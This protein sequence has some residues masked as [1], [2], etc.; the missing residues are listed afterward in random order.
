MYHRHRPRA[1]FPLLVCPP[2][3][4]AHQPLPRT[5]QYRARAR[6]RR[7][8]GPSRRPFRQNTAASRRASAR[9]P[10][11]P[12][13]PQTRHRKNPAQ[14]RRALPLFRGRG[15]QGLL[16]VAHVWPHRQLSATKPQTR[17]YPRPR[18]PALIPYRPRAHRGRSH[19]R[20]V[21][22]TRP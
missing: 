20:A 11:P 19:S 12:P 9:A 8:Q 21:I 3:I 1:P 2:G 4:G 15:K 6:P 22:N 14:T 18:R 16:P 13:R 5:R 7:V 17:P 10:S